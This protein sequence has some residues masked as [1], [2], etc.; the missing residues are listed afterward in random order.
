MKATRDGSITVGDEQENPKWL[1]NRI[2][3]ARLIAE[4]QGYVSYKVVRIVAKEMDLTPDQ[5]L[6]LFDRA[7]AEWEVIKHE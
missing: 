3:F 6:E 5:V 4:M 1:D 2:Q 7:V